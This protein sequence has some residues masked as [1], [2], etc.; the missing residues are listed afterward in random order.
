M[1]DHPR[2][3]LLLILDGAGYHPDAD[4]NAVTAQHLPRL[5]ERM[6]ADNFAVLEAAQEAVGLEAGQ[7]GNSEAGHL[8]IGA[9]HVVSSMCRHICETYEDGRWAADPF[10][11]RPALAGADSCLHIVGLLSDAGV[12]ALDRSMHQA[13]KIASAKGIAEVIVHPVLDGVDS[14]AGS[15]P[16]ILADL[17]EQIDGLPGVRLGVIVGRKWFCDR[18][19]DLSVSQQVID[20]FRGAEALPAYSDEALAAHLRSSG[21][22]DFPAHCV[23]GGRSIRDGETVLLTS[24]RADRAR[25]VA[26]VLGQTQPVAMLVDPGETVQVDHIFFP[27]KPLDRGLAHV[28]KDAGLSTVRIAEKCKFPHVTFFLNGFDAGL[29][30]EGI[31]IPSIPEAEICEKPEM[32]LEGICDEVVKALRDPARRVVIGNLANL[33]QVGHLGNYELATRAAQVV[34]EAYARLA[35]EAA[36]NGWT[37]LLTADH[38]NADRL[39]GADGSPF[40][41]HT[42]RPVPFVAVAAPG[43]EGEWLAREGS[44]SNVAATVLAALDVPKPE[45]MDPPLM[46]FHER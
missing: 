26:T 45:W 44:L 31:C 37:L 23:E 24:H 21:E 20:A 35:A 4:G 6:G 33:D 15:A 41:S 32:S 42:D 28:L 9:G 36:A 18:S 43:L 5:F 14:L 25:Q 27:Q 12:H 22:M 46:A 11:D 1:S 34:D 38:G 19:G 3:V 10:W 39:T 8:T 13:V 40:G 2:K 16:R 7:V 29:E 30:G 17:H